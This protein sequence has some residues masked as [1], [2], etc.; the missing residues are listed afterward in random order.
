VPRR[1]DVGTGP[2]PL[3]AAACRD[4]EVAVELPPSIAGVARGAFSFHI[5]EALRQASAGETWRELFARTVQAL[6][7]D[8][9]DQHPQLSGDGLDAPAFGDVRGGAR[10]RGAGH[11]LLGLAGRSDPYGLKME[12][13]RRHRGPWR[14]ASPPSF[15]AGDRLRVDLSH[16][17]ERALYVYL[18]DVGLT[19]TVTLLFPDLDGHE[20]LDERRPPLVVGER[21]GDALELF[22]PDDL[23]QDQDEGVGHLLLVASERRLST[24]RL[25][26]GSVRILG[27]VCAIAR[28]YRLRRS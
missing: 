18:L 2:R 14:H 23:P 7:A 16:G 17:H 11:R 9:L 28:R 25:L 4:D 22:V 8:P 3:V 21:R 10:K 15:V 24:A 13:Y 12:L 27:D 20:A 6:A 1:R 26:S 19:C 5:I